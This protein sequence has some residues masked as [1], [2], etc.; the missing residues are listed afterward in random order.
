L[1]FFII[2]TNKSAVIEK[3]FFLTAASAPIY[4]WYA[5]TGGNKK[6]PPVSAL[7]IYKFQDL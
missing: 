7:F 6:S 4:V 2:K 1:Q 5:D 3:E